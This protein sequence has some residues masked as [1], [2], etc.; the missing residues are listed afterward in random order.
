M[1][2]RTVPSTHEQ[3]LSQTWDRA[4]SDPA[5]ATRSDA[6]DA[7]FRYY[8]P[9][10]TDLAHRYATTHGNLSRALHAAEV[11]LARAILD[12]Q[13][14]DYTR[15]ESFA[16]LSIDRSLRAPAAAVH[17]RPPRIASDQTR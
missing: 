1:R 7:L 8:L 10:A 4:R 9:L 5:P 14:R 12:W 2:T 16:R 15:F 11:G 17:G 13:H 3:S 6:E